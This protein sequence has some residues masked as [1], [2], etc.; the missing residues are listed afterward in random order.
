MGKRILCRTF[1]M[2]TIVGRAITAPGRLQTLNCNCSIYYMQ[3]RVLITSIPQASNADMRADIRMAEVD[4]VPAFRLAAYRG[5]Y[6]SG[7]K[8]QLGKSDCVV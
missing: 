6:A 2:L 1:E 3:S 7:A 4:P 8:L 5:I